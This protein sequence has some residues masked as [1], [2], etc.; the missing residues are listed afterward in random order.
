[1]AVSQN[2]FSLL[3]STPF[4]LSLP[5][6]FVT[7]RETI[8]EQ[9]VY[10]D[11][12]LLQCTVTLVHNK[13]TVT[14]C[15]LVYTKQK[16]NAIQKI[17]T[18]CSRWAVFGIVWICKVSQKLKCK[19]LAPA[20]SHVRDGV[21]W[22]VSRP[23]SVCSQRDCGKGWSSLVECLCG[24]CDV[25]SPA[26]SS[27]QLQYKYKNKQEQPNNQQKRKSGVGRSTRRRKRK[28]R[29]V[30]HWSLPLSLFQFRLWVSIFVLLHAAVTGPNQQGRVTMDWSSKVR[31]PSIACS[32][33]ADCL[34]PAGSSE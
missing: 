18:M 3:E 16:F 15:W 1:M 29:T 7:R 25:L 20:Y 8:W 4:P 27:T 33:W 22:E 11:F 19:S 2:I 17:I 31:S 12:F 30:G 13:S 23:L 21:Q 10:T 32:L 5:F 34:G 24:L 26:I 6:L 28:K 9:G 14:I